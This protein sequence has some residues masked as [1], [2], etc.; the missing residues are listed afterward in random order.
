MEIIGN[1]RPIDFKYTLQENEIIGILKPN[2]TENEI[3]KWSE[4]PRERSTR[5]FTTPETSVRSRSR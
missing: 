1:T 5:E 4:L 2:F 3:K